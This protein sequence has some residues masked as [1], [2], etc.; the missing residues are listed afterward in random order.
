MKIRK[1]TLKKEYALRYPKQT[2]IFNSVL[3][4]FLME[5]EGNLFG[6]PKLF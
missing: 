2:K 4:K 1:A 5:K 3:E 6:L